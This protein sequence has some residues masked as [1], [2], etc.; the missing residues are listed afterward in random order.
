MNGGNSGRISNFRTNFVGRVVNDLAESNRF[1]LEEQILSDDADVDLTKLAQYVLK[2]HLPSAHRVAVW[3]L[4][5]EV[6]SSSHEGRKK[7]AEHRRE[8]AELLLQSLN[9]MRMTSFKFYITQ[10]NIRNV[11]LNELDIVRMILLSKGCLPSFTEMNCWNFDSRVQLFIAKFMLKLCDNSWLDAFWLTKFFDEMLVQIFESV[12]ISTVIC[13]IK[14]FISNY[15][16]KLATELQELHLWNRLP[17]NFYVRTALA[18]LFSYEAILRLWDKLCCCTKDGITAMISTTL[19]NYLLEINQINDI[20]LLLEERD[21]TF[22]INTQL[23]VETEN[24]IITKSIENV[25]GL[26]R[27]IARKFD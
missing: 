14:E 5:L 13:Y 9:I 15:D 3:K 20:R 18:P 22:T 10:S 2:Y 16:S 8:E 24:Q 4:L 17:I 1:Q 23:K 27:L 19:L 21:G 7:I 6:S 26:G 11:S 25:N 12:D